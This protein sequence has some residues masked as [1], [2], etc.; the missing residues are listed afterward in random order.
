MTN[1]PNLALTATRRDW[2]K[3]LAMTLLALGHTSAVWGQVN[4]PATTEGNVAGMLP[5]VPIQAP[6][7]PQGSKADQK[8]NLGAPKDPVASFIESLKGND[9][10]VQVVVGQGR[11]LTLK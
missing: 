10:V 2:L 11:L 6:R 5:N 3:L 4:D 8:Y 1:V 9:A 7:A